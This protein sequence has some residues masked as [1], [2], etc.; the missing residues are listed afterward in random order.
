MEKPLPDKHVAV[1]Y[2]SWLP[3]GIEQ[4][5]QF[6]QSYKKNKAGYSHNLVIVF[7]GLA[8]GVDKNS[9]TTL[10][11]DELPKAE[12]LEMDSGQDIDAYFFAANKRSEGL[13]L[14]LNTVS[15]FNCHNWLLSYIRSFDASTGA[16]GATGSYQS[17]YTTVFRTSKW[18]WE[19]EKGPYHN[20]R[21]YKMFLKAILYWRFLIPPFPNPH[22]RTNAFMIRRVD[23]LSLKK[24]NLKKKFDAY[25]FES[26][27]HSMTNQL[28]K[29]GYTVDVMGRDGNKYP[30]S[31]WKESNTFWVNDQP[32]LIISD[33]QTELYR[34]AG[35]A[36]K[37][38]LGY[39]AWGNK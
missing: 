6:I 4:L 18:A 28:L 34:T 20:F 26:G 2:L 12:M 27:R 14:F 21:K 33:N 31:R 7:N 15:R 25:L 23:F 29:R 32:N 3:Y 8:Y 11:K 38:Y 24:R 1:V 37:K 36:Y 22:L 35:T 19:S 30:L 16:L 17:L 13:I 5:Q 39:I 9:F 10:V